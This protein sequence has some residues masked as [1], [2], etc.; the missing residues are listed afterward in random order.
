[1]EVLPSRE[2]TRMAGVQ[3]ASSASPLTF[4][5]NESFELYDTYPLGTTRYASTMGL[6]HIH[7]I[8]AEDQ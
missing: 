5:V 3:P 7:H 1:M 2:T 6:K 8:D 4:L